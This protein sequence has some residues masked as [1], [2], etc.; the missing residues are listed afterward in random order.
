MIRSFVAIDL[1]DVVKER[2]ELVMEA[3]R[4]QMPH[5][6][7]RWSRSG[8]IHLTLKFLGNVEEND[9]PRIQEVLAQIAQR[10]PPFSF[11]IGELGCF[12]NLN[13]PRVVWIGVQEGQG[14]LVALQREIEESL[15]PL[16]FKPEK[17]AFHP[18]LTLGRAKRHIRRG[19]QRRL[20]ELISDATVEKLARVRTEGFRLMRSDLYPDG[21]VY[22][23]LEVFPLGQP[24]ESQ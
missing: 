24:E 22:T 3:L 6:D 4:K 13:R 10:Y 11:T 1:P 17:R 19:D 9:L 5:A 18:H 14:V 20:G 16:G 23:S 8:S 2:L 12:P 7:I 15:A 21:A